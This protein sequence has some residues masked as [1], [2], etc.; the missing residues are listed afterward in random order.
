[1]NGIN[2]K[3]INLKLTSIVVSS[4]FFLGACGATL[5]NAGDSADDPNMGSDF[6][7]ANICAGKTIF[8]RLGA[9]ACLSSIDNRFNDVDAPET[10]RKFPVVATDTD[11]YQGASEIAKV[12]RTAFVDCGTTG[13][14]E[15][16]IANC[17]DEDSDSTVKNG[18]D[19]TWDGSKKSN[20]AHGTWRLVT[21]SGVNSE[22]WRDERTGLLWSARIVSGDLV[23][24]GTTWCQAAGNNEAANGICNNITNQPNLANPRSICGE[25][26]ENGI[27][28]SEALAGEDWD[29]GVYHVKKGGIGLNEG[30]VNWYLPSR[31]DYMQAYVN[32]MGYVLPDLLDDAFGSTYYWTSSVI[33]G[34]L[35]NA[36]YFVAYANGGAYVDVNSRDTAAGTGVRCVGR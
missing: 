15:E 8:G 6:S 16:R 5:N 32:G 33:S 27:T 18:D 13:S 23:S 29:T 1:M 24:G 17:A 28:R 21:R 19:A 10:K 14:V 31:E 35:D 2:E 36:W 3:R 22:V 25:G 34:N 26:A 9:A 7:A 20:T 12:D 11:G 30:G 4:V